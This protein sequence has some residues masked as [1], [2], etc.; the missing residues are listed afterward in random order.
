MARAWIADFGG[1]SFRSHPAICFQPIRRGGIVL[2]PMNNAGL[3][4]PA[5]QLRHGLQVRPAGHVRSH[6]ALIAP[7]RHRPI[8][9]LPVGEQRAVEKA[10]RPLGLSPCPHGVDEKL[11]HKPK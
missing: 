5:K 1:P 9:A 2:R 10:V 8:G 3:I 7:K 6:G 4:A 11:R